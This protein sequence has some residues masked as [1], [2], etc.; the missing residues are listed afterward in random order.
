MATQKPDVIGAMRR[1]KGMDAGPESKT[2]DIIWEAAQRTMPQVD[3]N[4]LFGALKKMMETGKTRLIRAGN[5][6]FLVTQMAPDTVELHQFSTEAPAQMVNSYK[7]LA[8]NLKNYGIKRA[9]SLVDSPAYER[10]A[11]SAGLN[12]RVE[13]TQRMDGKQMVPAFRLTVEV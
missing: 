2:E 10:M 11:K 8:N 12:A 6:V 13:Q 4:R 5:S 7:M 9:V 3:K 1:Q